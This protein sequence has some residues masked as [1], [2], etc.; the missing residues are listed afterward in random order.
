MA[1]AGRKLRVLFEKRKNS[2]VDENKLN[3]NQP[4]S[5]VKLLYY[6]G[7][8][9]CGHAKSDVNLFYFFFLIPQLF[10]KC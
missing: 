7:S 1:Y 2:I 3:I 6:Y 5:F 10:L 8:S 9:D 4:F